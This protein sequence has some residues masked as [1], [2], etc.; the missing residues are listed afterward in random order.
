M[1]RLKWVAGDPATAADIWRKLRRYPALARVQGAGL[2]TP[3]IDY[4]EGGGDAPMFVV[5]GLADR[6][7]PPENARKLRDRFPSRVHLTE[8]PGLG[9][10]LFLEQPEKVANA[11]LSCLQAAY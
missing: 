9:H 2:Q 7:A 11:V 10:M 4:Y 6:S 3:A 8:M 1:S 5:Q